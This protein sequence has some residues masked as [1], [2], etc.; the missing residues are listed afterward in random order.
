M[1]FAARVTD[2]QVCPKGSPGGEIETGEPTVVIEGQRA[3]RVGDMCSCTDGPAKIGSGSPT[4]I[5][6]G[7]KA[8][9]VGDATCHH[10][11]ITTG[12]GT[13]TIGDGGGGGSSAMNTAKQNAAPFV[14]A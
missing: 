3:A 9:R 13:V 5:I 1:P 11:K 4:V 10:G 12:A 14:R 7:S 8:A 2:L 6:G